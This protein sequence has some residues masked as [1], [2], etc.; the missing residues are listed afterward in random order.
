MDIN[1]NGAN[2]NIGSVES[3][4]HYSGD[5]WKIDELGHYPAEHGAM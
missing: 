1:T 3:L 4:D 5:G 2:P